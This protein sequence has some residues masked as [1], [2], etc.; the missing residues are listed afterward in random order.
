MVTKLGVDP[1]HFGIIMAVNLAIGLIHP[2]LGPALFVTCKIGGVTIEETT[3]QAL[4]P[5]LVSLIAAL[6]VCT[7]WPG[8]VLFVPRLFTH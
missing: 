6:L 1:V 7:F 8:L 4:W 2:P 5:F 3:I